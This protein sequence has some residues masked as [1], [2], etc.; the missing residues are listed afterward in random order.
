M[1]ESNVGEWEDRAITAEAALKLERE[2]RE[3]QDGLAELLEY[4]ERSLGGAEKYRWG[5]GTVGQR[6]RITAEAL[7]SVRDRIRSLQSSDQKGR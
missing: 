4:V 6:V 7:E 1:S 3:P 2:A 5:T